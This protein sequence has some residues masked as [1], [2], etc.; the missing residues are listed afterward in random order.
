VVSPSSKET[1]KIILIF[2]DNFLVKIFLCALAHGENFYAANLP[3]NL[4]CGRV[5]RIIFSNN[6]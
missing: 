2:S 4:N 3:A 6:Y 1:C 5:P